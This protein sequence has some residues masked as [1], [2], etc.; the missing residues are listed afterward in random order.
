MAT[1]P[2]AAAP[3]PT[4]IDA[5][6]MHEPMVTM[7][8]PKR[9]ILTLKDYSRLIFEPGPREV[10]AS[11]V[12]HPYLAA[13]GATVY[14]PA[15]APAKIDVNPRLIELAHDLWE[16]GELVNFAQYIG[17]GQA[18]SSQ[19]EAARATK[20]KEIDELVKT[21]GSESYAEMQA[22]V[23]REGLMR[24][25][26]PP[27]AN[28]DDSAPNTNPCPICGVPLHI[29]EVHQCPATGSPAKA[30][31]PPPQQSG[32]PDKAKAKARGK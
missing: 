1:R 31:D 17:D 8:F 21:H 9:V 12:D 18:L 4:T 26:H 20:Q 22:R 29:G 10:P 16:A 25:Q 14:K 30:P 3:D 19:F 23:E 32:D 11:L 2:F 15:V 27:V 24:G 5:K 7:L 28:A 13:C 6:D